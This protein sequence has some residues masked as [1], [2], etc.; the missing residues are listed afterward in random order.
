[1]DNKQL[2]N[3]KFGTWGWS[4]VIYTMLLYYFW[5]GLSGDGMNVYTTAFANT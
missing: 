2:T 5:A 3:S 1:M 4:M